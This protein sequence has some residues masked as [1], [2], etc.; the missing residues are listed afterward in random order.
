MSAWDFKNRINRAV[1]LVV[2]NVPSLEPHQPD[3]GIRLSIEINKK[4]SIPL[5][6]QAGGKI[7]NHRCFADAALIIDKT[8]SPC[9]RSSKC[10]NSISIRRNKHR[11][12]LLL[13]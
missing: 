13:E 2:E 10:F 5:M 3:T 1:F 6:C 9:H 4:N 11:V 7:Y 12:L 8:D